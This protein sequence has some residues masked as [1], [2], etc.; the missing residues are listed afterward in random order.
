MS[1]WINA[2]VE[3]AEAA[4]KKSEQRIK[5]QRITMDKKYQTRDGRAVRILATDMK[6]GNG[7]EQVVALVNY[8]DGEKLLTT[9]CYGNSNVRTGFDLIPVPTKHEGWAVVDPY[10]TLDEM[11]IQMCRSYQALVGE[12]KR[13]GLTVPR[14]RIAHVTW[15][16]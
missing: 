11:P 8:D 9:D 15:E 14:F 13:E 4:I 16:D 10:S 2:V 3:E 6:D 1:P 12:M 5:E 7:G